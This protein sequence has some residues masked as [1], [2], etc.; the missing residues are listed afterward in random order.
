MR[1]MPLSSQSLIFAA[2]DITSRR[3]SARATAGNRTVPCHPACGRIQ[4]RADLGRA[5]LVAV[6][7]ALVARDE[8]HRAVR[9]VEAA[10]PD[11]ASQSNM[12]A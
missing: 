6:D 7:E 5:V 12:Q 2:S 10:H 9:P 3:S 4:I 11:E 8:E 1:S